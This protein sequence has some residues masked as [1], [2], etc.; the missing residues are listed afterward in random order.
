MWAFL[1]DQALCL[2]IPTCDPMQSQQCWQL[3]AIITSTLQMGAWET[4]L[5]VV[6]LID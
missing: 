3:D 1:M 5:F 6:V 4:C 2:L